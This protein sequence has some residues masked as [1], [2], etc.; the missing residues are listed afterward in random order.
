MKQISNNKQNML[1]WATGHDF[2]GKPKLFIDF[3]HL[4]ISGVLLHLLA[5]PERT[6][7]GPDDYGYAYTMW[8]KI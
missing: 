7:I 6:L 5:S 1:E 4:R 8:E 3:A 2:L